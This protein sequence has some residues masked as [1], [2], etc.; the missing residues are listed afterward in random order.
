MMPQLS[1]LLNLLRCALYI[2]LS[3]Y[4]YMWPNR[5]VWHH[6]MSKYYVASPTKCCPFTVLTPRVCAAL[7]TMICYYWFCL[8]GFLQFASC[9]C[10][11]VCT[12]QLKLSY[13]IE[14]NYFLILIFK[15]VRMG[16]SA[17]AHYCNERNM[18]SVPN[19]F[20]NWQIRQLPYCFWSCFKRI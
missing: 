1:L 18:V 20:T 16:S 15:M 11:C 17:R 12:L 8:F 2:Y 9:V 7:R 13:L 14:I 10:V 4:I 5:T 6:N 3:L 19:K